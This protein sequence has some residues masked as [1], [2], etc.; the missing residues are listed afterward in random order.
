MLPAA[1][2]LRIASVSQEM[3]PYFSQPAARC[4]RRPHELDAAVLRRFSIQLEVRGRRRR[5]HAQ[6]CLPHT[7]P[8][9]CG[10]TGLWGRPF[11]N[12]HDN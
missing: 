6:L 5:V 2:A 12:D 11:Q 3:E 4:D 1:H 7:K 8:A 9:S 10:P